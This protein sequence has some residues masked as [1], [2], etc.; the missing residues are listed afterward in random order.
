MPEISADDDADLLRRAQA[1]DQAAFAVLVTRHRRI[2]WGVCLRITGN[3]ADAEDALQ[4]TLVAADITV[5]LTTGVAAEFTWRSGRKDVWV[6]VDLPRDG[7]PR[8]VARAR[9]RF[10]HQ[11]KER[12]HADAAH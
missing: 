4:D 12:H 6:V 3:S 8:R 1:A 10:I 5:G 9:A 2:A 11:L 7:V